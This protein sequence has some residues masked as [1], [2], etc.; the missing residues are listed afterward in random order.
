M[1]MNAPSTMYNLNQSWRGRLCKDGAVVL[2]LLYTVATHYR[3]KAIVIENK[4][5]L[6]SDSYRNVDAVFDTA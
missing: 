2:T 5:M 1:N 6:L 4:P 3:S